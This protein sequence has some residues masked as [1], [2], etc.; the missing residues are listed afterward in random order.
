[1]KKRMKKRMVLFLLVILLVSGCSP[2]RQEQGATSPKIKIGINQFADHPALDAVRLGFEQELK[3][4]GIGVEIDWKNS[5]ADVNTSSKISEKF[6]EDEVD[7]IL[8][9]A[10][11]A[12]QSAKMATRQKKIP[13]LFSA[14]TDPVA[15]E[16]VADLGQPGDNLSGTT[17]MAPMEEQ[18]R[19]FQAI[20]PRIKTIGIIYNTGEANSEAQIKLA[21]ELGSQMGLEIE[22][23]G[24]SNINEVGQAAEAL[25]AKVD[26]IYTIADNTVASAIGVVAQ[27]ANQA[28]L[29]TVGAEKAH[30][31]GGILITEGLSYFEL[32][33]Q[34]GQMAKRILLDHEDIATMA[35]ERLETTT[36]VVN[37][38]TIAQ[39]GL[40]Q[41]EVFAGT[42]QVGTK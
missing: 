10:T 24:I 31:E 5:Q 25:V 6:V 23:I 32:G 27:K 18:L 20:D 34:T 11:L 13:V 30:V 15:A 3:T 17:D 36:R 4:L 40:G 14:V 12:A 35:V 37:V 16:L 19:L 7:L 33:R 39:L 21:E 42:D 38:E 2:S 9:I 8:A 41:L 29:V 1:M 28:G 26:G 22:A